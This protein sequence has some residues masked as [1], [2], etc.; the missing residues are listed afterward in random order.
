MNTINVIQDF[1]NSRV[2]EIPFLWIL[3]I[4]CASAEE[5]DSIIVN[6]ISNG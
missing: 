2:Q 6:F 5:T 4:S 1:C 3:V